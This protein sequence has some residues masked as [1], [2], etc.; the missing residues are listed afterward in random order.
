MTSNLGADLIKKTTE[1]GFG[2]QEGSLDYDHIKEKIEGAVKKHFKPEFLNRLNDMVIFEPLNKESLLQVIELEVKKVQARLTRREVFITLD[3]KAKNFLVDKGFQPEMGARPLRRTIE[4]Y[5]EDPLA[6]MLLSH[7]DQSRTC[8]V[9]VDN[10]HLIFIDQEVHERKKEKT[11]KTP[12]KKRARDQKGEEGEGGEKERRE[13]S[14]EEK[15]E[16]KET[17]KE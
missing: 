12:S 16:T 9:S 1:V 11:E 13:G 2:A 8:L 5:L 10:D 4:Q 3:D 14:D 7:P 15:Q 6:E 17:K